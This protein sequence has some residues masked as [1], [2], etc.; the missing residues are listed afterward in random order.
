M[1]SLPLA[2]WRVFLWLH[3]V[4]L[5]KSSDE[6]DTIVRDQ[7]KLTDDTVRILEATVQVVLTRFIILLKISDD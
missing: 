2:G 6:A 5:E 4:S 3:P 1:G 7:S